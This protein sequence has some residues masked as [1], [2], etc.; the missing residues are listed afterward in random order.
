MGKIKPPVV[1]RGCLAAYR[2]G[3]DGYYLGHFVPF[4]KDSR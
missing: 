3:V 1:S 4:V 2:F